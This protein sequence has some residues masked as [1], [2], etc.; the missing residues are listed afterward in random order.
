MARPA[1]LTC[2]SSPD[3][4]NTPGPL[5]FL[6]RARTLVRS[7]FMGLGRERTTVFTRCRTWLLRVVIASAPRLPNFKSDRI[8]ASGLGDKH[9]FVGVRYFRTRDDKYFLRNSLVDQNAI[10]FAH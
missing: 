2:R 6:S 9:P 1:S 7:R 4:S 5:A 3:S 10:A 8:F